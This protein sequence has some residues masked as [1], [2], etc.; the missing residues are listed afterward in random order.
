MKEYITIF[1]AK[2]A[3]QLLKAGYR[4]VDIKPDKND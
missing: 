1:T 3:R 2:L 4:L